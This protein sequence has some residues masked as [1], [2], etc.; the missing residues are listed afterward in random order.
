MIIKD[1]RTPE[2]KK[3]HTVMVVMTDSFMSGWGAARGGSSVAGWACAS[4]ENVMDCEKW[5]RSRTDAKRVRVVLDSP[6]RYRPKNAKHFHI[7][8]WKEGKK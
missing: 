3:T 8:V 4:S 7:Y 2:Q 1:D 5:V 6:R